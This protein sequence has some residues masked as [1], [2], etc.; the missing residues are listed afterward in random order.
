M[1]LIF[2][3][4]SLGLQVGNSMEEFAEDQEIMVNSMQTHNFTAAG[5]YLCNFSWLFKYSML[6]VMHLCGFY[7]LFYL[8]WYIS[9]MHRHSYI[10]FSAVTSGL[11]HFPCITDQNQLYFPSTHPA[12]F[13]VFWPKMLVQTH[14]EVSFLAYNAVSYRIPA[15]TFPQVGGA[16]V[17][18]GCTVCITQR[19][20]RTLIGNK[21]AQNL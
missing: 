12:I 18:G 1:V 11:Q 15:L 3:S 16:V 10:L 14:P 20:P 4:L 7:P 6:F 21:D 9:L 13:Y 17:C 19:C 8:L 5:R 2:G